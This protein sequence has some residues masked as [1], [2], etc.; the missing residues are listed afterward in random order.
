V[1]I[2]DEE[3]PLKENLKASFCL[4]WYLWLIL[5]ATA[6]FDF[7]ITV[8]FMWEDGV[9]FERNFV[10]RWLASAIGILP[11]VFVGKILQILAA[12]GF[13]ALSLT[14]ARATLVLILL[15]N[16]VAVIINLL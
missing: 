15:L 12:I 16:L 6:F 5:L 10:V 1:R 11:G 8:L 13:S 2:L 7:V 9:Q 4:Y 14:F 3:I